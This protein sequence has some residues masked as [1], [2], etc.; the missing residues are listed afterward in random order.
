MIKLLNACAGSG[1]AVPGGGALLTYAAAPTF[2]LMAIWS[3]LSS[4]HPDICG[5]GPEASPLTGMEAMYVLM[6][7]FHMPAWLG[8]VSRRKRASVD[9][10]QPN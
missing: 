9:R 10:I 7:L 8:L 6:S 4:G 2:A 5:N 1:K 3:G